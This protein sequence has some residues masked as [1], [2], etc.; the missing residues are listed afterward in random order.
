M[1]HTGE[2]RTAPSSILNPVARMKFNGSMLRRLQLLRSANS[3][4]R[5]QRVILA[6]CARGIEGF[7]YW[8]DHWVWTDDPRLADEGMLSGVPL[9][10]FDRQRELVQFLFARIDTPEDGV[11]EKSS[12]MGFS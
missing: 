9:D 5:L 6:R 4:P 10:L 1:Q 3:S 7:F 8:T 11:V 2:L 12:D